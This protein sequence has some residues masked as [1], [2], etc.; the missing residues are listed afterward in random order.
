VALETFTGLPH[1]LEFVRNVEGAEWYDDSIATAPERTLASLA[2]FES[3]PIILLAGG[4]DKDLPWEA[5]AETVS[6]RV[7]H[8]IL[9][10]EASTKI[11]DAMKAASGNYLQS[12]DLCDDLEGAVARASELAEDGDVVLLAPGGTSFDA[13]VDFEARGERF[14]ALVGDL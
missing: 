9:F 11:A 3:E 1:R 2:S 12:L 7:D 8:L 14:K 13:Y 6:H 4:R 10:G 5:F